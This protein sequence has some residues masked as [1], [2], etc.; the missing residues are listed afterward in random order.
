MAK[1]FTRQQV[2]GRLRKTIDEG[3][4]IIGAG[5]GAG[6]V[7]KC[8]ELGG[9][10]LVIVYCTGKSRMMGLPTWILGDPNTLTLELA[11]EILY[12]V[13]ETPVIAGIDCNDPARNKE[14]LL[15]KFMDMRFSG[16]INYPSVAMYGLECIYN[17]NACMKNEVE[18]LRL[19]R[20]KMD[21]FTMSYAYRLLEAKRF[22]EVVDVIIPHAGWT[23][24]GLVG[25]PEVTTLPKAA[26][27]VQKMAVAAKE[28]N[29]EVIVLC[30]GGPIIG[31][32][33]T[34]YIYEHTDVVGFIGGSSIER[35]PLEN[36]LINIIKAF[37]SK[38][39]RKG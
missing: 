31:P 17:Y 3:K 21:I 11:P 20:D 8:I 6:I 9:I 38:S 16:V 22:A 24:G 39:T 28:V 1:R 23:G 35:I 30:H 26:K 25:A 34:A 4:P 36:A 2:L 29:P 32:E 12:V 14:E 33:D 13:K 27:L 7:A 10:D 5:A 37:K 18:T 19:A 15:K